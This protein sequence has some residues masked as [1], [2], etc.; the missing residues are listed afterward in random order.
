MNTHPKFTLHFPRFVP[1]GQLQRLDWA[2]QLLTAYDEKYKGALPLFPDDPDA[3]EAYIAARKAELVLANEL[4]RAVDNNE[5]LYHGNI[6][7]RD[8]IFLGKD[9]D[10]DIIVTHPVTPQESSASRLKPGFFQ[11]LLWM[12]HTLNANPL[13]ND[14]I[15]KDLGTFD[16]GPS[17]PDPATATVHPYD[18]SNGSH[19]KFYIPILDPV[20]QILV[21][22]DY[23]D[24]N[25]KTFLAVLNRAHFTDSDHPFTETPSLRSY[26]F[27]PLGKNNEPIGILAHYSRTFTLK[28]EE[29]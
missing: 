10:P 15:R 29:L 24:G 21:Q 16:P 23:H 11:R 9:G 2:D 27:T 7:L 18:K 13:C 22:C 8:H 3:T 26:T 14:N 17:H 12:A 25:G 19:A 4:Q 6:N 20:T 5:E 28:S 1:K